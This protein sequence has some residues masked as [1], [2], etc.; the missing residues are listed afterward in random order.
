MADNMN[1]PLGQKNQE[2]FSRPKSDWFTIDKMIYEH[3]NYFEIPTE[4]AESM[5]FLSIKESLNHHYKN[6]KFY[7]QLC[8]EY[9]FKPDD[10]TCEKDFQKVPLLPDTFF[11]EYPKENPRA[12]YDWLKKISTVDLGNYDYKGKDLQG[13]LR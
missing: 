1:G 5:R 4:K 3:T 2:L 12:I 9:Q 13:F 8:K 11:K 10:I 6:S 7:H